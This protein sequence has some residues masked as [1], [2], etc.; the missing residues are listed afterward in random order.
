MQFELLWEQCRGAFSSKRVW[1][2]AKRLALSG[3]VGLGRHTITGL[4]CASNRQAHDWSAAYRL[5]SRKRFFPAELFGTVRRA[6][7]AMAE[8]G[9]PLVVSMDDSLLRKTGRKVHGVAWKRDPMSPPFHVNFVRGVRVLQISA[10][11]AGKDAPGEARMVPVD[12]IHAPSPA[13]PGKK[14]N[15]EELE[16]FKNAQEEMRLGRQGIRR[17]AALRENM[18]K[19][20]P[21]A[22]RPLWVLVDG[23]YTNK[24][25][26]R[27]IPANTVVIGRMRGDAKLFYPP[28]EGKVDAK[29]RKRSYGERA[30]TPEDLRKDETVEWKIVS[31]WACGKQHNF[32]VKTLDNVK[33]PAA[34]PNAVMRLVVI[35]PLGYRP[36]KG[37]KLLYRQPAYLICTDPAIPLEEVLQAYV[38]RWDVEVNFRDEKQ[39]MGIEEPQVRRAD[40][41]ENVPAF[42]TAAYAL[43][44]VSAVKAFGVGGMPS[45][46]PLPKWRKNEKPRRASTAS[47]INQLRYELW[48]AAL[49]DEEGHFSGFVYEP[50]WETKPEKYLPNL[51]ASVL[52][53]MN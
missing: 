40:A 3:L 18:D 46:I 31:A 35:A 48:G 26:L 49:G 28:A 6:V 12:F 29:G 53:A 33:W 10:A 39:L 14:A 9:K 8:P 42:L 47:L 41:V 1:E 2:R 51:A 23:S 44:L 16:A 38:W 19:D 20:E 34:G 17:I 25:V 13:K 22:R 21:V 15:P 5:F 27:N 52:Y 45:A 32:K 11:I 37:A 36:R 4:L 7:S 24:R 50:S 30:P 43:L